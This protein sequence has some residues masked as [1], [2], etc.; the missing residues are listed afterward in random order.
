MTDYNRDFNSGVTLKTGSANG[1]ARI[2]YD[3][4]LEDSTTT[5]TASSSLAG[6]PVSALTNSM[7]YEFWKTD[8][9]PATLNIDLGSS[10]TL[11]AVGIGA[12]SLAGY[13]VL[14]EYSTDDVTYSTFRQAEFLNNKNAL[15]MA[16]DVTAQYVRLTISV[17]D[18]TL[19]VAEP[20]IAA[21]YV[22]YPLIMQ[23]AIYGGHTPSALARKTKIVPNKSEGG[24][25]LGRSVIRY[26]EMTSYNYQ[27]LEARWYRD[28]FDP[29]AASATSKPFFIAWRP[30]YYADE[31]VYGQ[32]IQDIEPS[33]QGVI[34]FMQ[35][36]FNVMGFR[37]NV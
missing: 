19:T 21:L 25:W 10:M 14:I 23:R 31:V 12:H 16:D 6:F 8:T 24:Q 33:N 37:E 28:N 22:G 36:S 2:L 7:T 20:K 4:W 1:L 3:N 29:F 9:F 5:V 27:N 35:V 30:D 17:D 13:S 26:G 18:A 15:I 11:G 32:T 34:D